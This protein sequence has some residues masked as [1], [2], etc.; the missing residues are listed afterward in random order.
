MK[1][2]AL[3]IRH[4]GGK[5]I[6]SILRYLH[7][8]ASDTLVLT[9]FRD[10]TNAQVLKDS[11]E[12]SGFK[13]FTSAP[14]LPKTNSV[15]I[16]S[17]HPFIPKEHPELVHSD[18]HRLASAT[19]QGFVVHGVYFAQNKAKASL[20][21]FLSESLDRTAN[22][23]CQIIGDFNT[24]LHFTDEESSTFHCT[25]EFKNLLNSG[26]IDSWRTRHPSSKEFSWQSNLGNGFRIDHILS[27]AEADSLISRVYY[28][29]TPRLTGITDHSALIVEIAGWVPHL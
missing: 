15:C 11:L 26:F 3:N 5:R 10:N 27:N 18:R 24:G 7:S 6:Q 16:F 13:Y 21:K 9:E 28:D 29:H 25:S 22:L 1:L 12:G 20:F 8:H 17:R 14:C 19:F 2:I 23:P 4:G